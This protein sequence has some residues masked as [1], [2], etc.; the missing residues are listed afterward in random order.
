MGT[1]HYIAC[2]KCKVTRDLDKFYNDGEG[3]KTR[4]DALKYTEELK[5]LEGSRFRAALLVS[6]MAD[7]EGHKCVYFN[8]FH[9][10]T[11]EMNPNSEDDIHY[12]EDTDFWHE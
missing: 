4:E 3:I 9:P 10:G 11:D 1:M 2:T 6:F 5:N 12:R 8:E 7:H